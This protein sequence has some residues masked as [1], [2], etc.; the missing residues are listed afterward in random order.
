MLIFSFDTAEAWP[1]SEEAAYAAVNQSRAE[2][3]A[4]GG[5]VQSET[6]TWTRHEYIIATQARI[7]VIKAIPMSFKLGILRIVGILWP[8]AELQAE[9]QRLT[10]S[11]STETFEPEI[12]TVAAS[13]RGEATN[14]TTDQI[15]TLLKA[16]LGRIDVLLDSAGRTGAQT[17]LQ[18]V[19]SW[20]PQVKLPQLY[21]IRGNATALLERTYAEVNRLA[22]TMV[23]WFS[24]YTYTPY[25][26]DEG[27]PLG[28]N[29]YGWSRRRQHILQHS[30]VRQ[31]S[32]STH[33]VLQRLS[34]PQLRPLR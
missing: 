31:P 26:D 9:L 20:Y 28:C 27:N 10:T 33:S 30:A 2:R 19:L 34:T 16:I 1:E 11:T 15:R 12:L 24:V 7:P 29:F 32:T 14:A 21:N 23:D 22:S 3:A 5:S 4:A 18:T 17:A 25:L 8:P 13:K 6:D